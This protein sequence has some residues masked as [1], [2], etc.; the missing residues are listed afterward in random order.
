MFDPLLL[1][2]FKS[3]LIDYNR[4]IDTYNKVRKQ[5]REALLGECLN[6][7]GGYF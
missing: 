7:K 4:L 5:K 1:L 2:Y 6:E 3:I